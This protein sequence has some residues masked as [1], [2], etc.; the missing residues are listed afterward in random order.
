MTEVAERVECTVIE[1]ERA[2]SEGKSAMNADGEMV[3]EVTNKTAQATNKTARRIV[4]RARR[5]GVLSGGTS[6]D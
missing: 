6:A 2:T 4:A 5:A 3:D 1:Y